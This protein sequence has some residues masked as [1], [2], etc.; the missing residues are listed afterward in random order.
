L[1]RL[2]EDVHEKRLE[3]L[4]AKLAKVNRLN[5]NITSE[6]KKEQNIE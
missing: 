6:N 5:D 2:L 3:A 1:T 4:K